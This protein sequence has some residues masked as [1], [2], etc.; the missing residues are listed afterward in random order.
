MLFGLELSPLSDAFSTHA[1]LVSV[2]EPYW[3]L[4]LA[5]MKRGRMMRALWDSGRSFNKNRV[6]SLLTQ[7]LESEPVVKVTNVVTKEKKQGRPIPLNTVALLKACS[8]ALGIGPHAAMQSAERLYLTGYLSYP[9]TESS[10][11]PKSFDIAGTLQQQTSDN[12]WGKYVSDL[13]SAGFNKSR[14]GVDMGDHPPITPCRAARAHELSGDLARVYDLV[15]RHFIASV[16]QDAV[17]QSTRVDFGLESLGEKG[18]FTLRGKEL[19]SPGFLAILLNKEYGEDAERETGGEDDEEER[20][21]PEFVKGETIPLVNTK[22]SSSSTKVAVVTA[23]QSA[24][25]ATLEIK[26][27][28]TT[29]PSYL[30]ESELIGMM[31]KN[32]I[33]TG[34]NCQQ[35]APRHS[36]F[37]PRY[38]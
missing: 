31:E 9:R 24:V 12:R 7:A 35:D 37:R 4:E 27:K 26:E 2:P 34:T 28:M 19:V 25:R 15:V 22:S 20:S 29:P 17:W 23:A 3:V 21:I 16:S 30:T 8:K 1:L 13:L 32:G 18:S 6:E 38:A 5:V 11:Y 33:G 36:G 10:T 14:G